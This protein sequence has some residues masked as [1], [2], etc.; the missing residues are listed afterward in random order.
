M[1]IIV[2]WCKLIENH[3]FLEDR[4]RFFRRTLKIFRTLK[5]YWW[6][7]GIRVLIFTHKF[8]SCVV[9]KY[10]QLIPSILTV[11]FITCTMEDAWGRIMR[12]CDG[13]ALRE[14]IASTRETINTYL[15]TVPS[16]HLIGNSK[17]SINE[18]VKAGTSHVLAGSDYVHSHFPYAALLSRSHGYLFVSASALIAYIPLRSKC[19]K[20]KCPL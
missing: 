2:I 9:W 11:L 13:T 18:L 14:N 5:I 16:L 15:K 20:L 10:Q 4:T 6:Y 17:Q 7:T 12:I 1:K 3:R 8:Y 19:W